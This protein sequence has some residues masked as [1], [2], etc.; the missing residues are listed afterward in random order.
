MFKTIAKFISGSNIVQAWELTRQKR[1]V[2]HREKINPLFGISRAM[3]WDIKIQ[4]RMPDGTRDWRISF[5]QDQKGMAH[6]VVQFESSTMR[7]KNY[8]EKDEILVEN[9]QN[10]ITNVIMYEG[11]EKF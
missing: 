3:S 5:P 7:E 11:Y 2:L 6:V 4:T 9:L 10:Y 1:R 8:I